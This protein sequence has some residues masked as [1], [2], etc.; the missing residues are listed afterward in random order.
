MT[1]LDRAVF[2]DIFDRVS[3]HLSRSK[4]SDRNMTSN[5][6][7]RYR[8]V[9]V[10]YWLRHYPSYPQMGIIFH[11]DPATVHREVTFL[12]PILCEVLQN[13]ISLPDW[14]KVES[15]IWRSPVCY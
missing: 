11:M 2:E 15:W 12:L 1:G 10:L 7:P 3:T 8:L 13:E 4:S 6:S 5:F 14:E 9:L